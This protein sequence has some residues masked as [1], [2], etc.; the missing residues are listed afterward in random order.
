M[1]AGRHLFFSKTILIYIYFVEKFCQ[2]DLNF[3][4]KNLDNVYYFIFMCSLFCC[5]IYS[6]LSLSG[7]RRDP[8]NHF[9]ISILRRIRLQ[10]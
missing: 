4:C 3:N 10:N 6:R 2:V 5:L 8:L 9:E 1:P 7:S